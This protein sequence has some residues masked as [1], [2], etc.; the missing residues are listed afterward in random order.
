LYIS[1]HI[2]YVDEVVESWFEVSWGRRFIYAAQGLVGLNRDDFCANL[3]IGTYPVHTLNWFEWCDHLIHHFGIRPFSYPVEPQ[4]PMP[5]LAIDVGKY[6]MPSIDQAADGEP[7]PITLHDEPQFDSYTDSYPGTILDQE[8]HTWAVLSRTESW[9][10]GRHYSVALLHRKDLILKVDNWA[11]M[12]QIRPTIT[13]VISECT[14]SIM[15]S[16]GEAVSGYKIDA[17]NLLIQRKSQL[18]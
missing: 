5:M 18:R 8:G 17:E 15:D 14:I 12:T 10:Y 16:K 13:P 2:A 6:I 4:I 3:G 11:V 7:L 1:P 9:H